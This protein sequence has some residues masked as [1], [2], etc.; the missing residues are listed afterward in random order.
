MGI[1]VIDALVVTLGL[2]NRDFRKG[3]KETEE[4]LKGLREGGA[5]TSNE[6]QSGGLRAAE[7]FRSLRN[8]L[9]GALV[10]FTGANSL[11]NFALNMVASD[12]ATGRLA[13]S[14]GVST[15]ELSA[16]QIAAQKAGGTAEDANASF[17]SMVSMFENIRLRGDLSQGAELAGL[18]VT[19]LSDPS[20]ALLQLA[21]ARQ[22]MSAPEYQNRLQHLGI[23]QGMINLLMKGSAEVRRL[24]DEA[25]RNG[26]AT[27]ESARAAQAYEAALVDLESTIKQGLRPEL[28]ELLKG[29]ASVVGGMKAANVLGPAVEGTLAAVAVAATAAAGPWAALAIA[30][31]SVIIA[32]RDLQK[33]RGMTPEQRK[34]FDD[35]G[36]RLRGEAWGEIKKGDVG[37]F[38]E[39]LWKGLSERAGISSQGNLGA[40]TVG[41]SGSFDAIR[42]RIVKSESGGNYNAV[43]YGE[44]SPKPITSMTLGELYDW[45][46][47]ALRA[48][49]RGRRGPHDVGSTGVGAY[50][51]ESGT[52]AEHASALYGANWRAHIFSVRTQDEVAQHLYNSVKGSPRALGATWNT[53]RPHV[54]RAPASA[55]GSNG[56]VHIGN[57]TVNTAATDGPGTARA[58]TDRLEQRGLVYQA[59][60]GMQQ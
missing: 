18:G 34:Q 32:Y 9:A 58:L 38:M 27:D 40:S 49:T 2:D 39:T 7:G 50:Q 28:T 3:R 51:F 52:L 46:R 1:N 21:D 36:S 17:Q 16:W 14:L 43:A 6:L 44:H 8:E 54:P 12:A 11:K 41:L 53:F 30:I 31:G 55:G 33:L 48:R 4:D 13:T 35:E 37:G 19:D 59:Q 5:R 60:S 24:T 42:T 20:K 29:F 25:A 26:A 23:S 15:Q 47:G 57:I 22:R 45:Q 56:T 10:L